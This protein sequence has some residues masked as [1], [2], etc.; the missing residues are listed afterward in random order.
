MYSAA[1]RIQGTGY[2]LSRAL[3][4]DSFSLDSQS[5]MYVYHSR[6]PLAKGRGGDKAKGIIV[7]ILYSS[8][9]VSVAHHGQE[10]F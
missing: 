10:L 8:E 7:A 2:V 3:V 1:N 4:F 9:H 5:N 6:V